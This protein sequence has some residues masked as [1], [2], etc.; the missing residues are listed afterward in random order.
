MEKSFL[1]FP[2]KFLRGEWVL[3]LTG[4]YSHVSQLWWS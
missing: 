3:L 4:G 2:S 1:Y